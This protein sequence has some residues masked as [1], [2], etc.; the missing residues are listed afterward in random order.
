M[1]FSPFQLAIF[2]HAEDQNAGN[3][4]VEAVAG[5]GKTTTL[6]ETIKRLKGSSIFLAFNKSIADELKKRGVNARTF[7][8]L[9]Y[10]VVLRH[11]KVNE[12]TT[13]KLQRIVDAK[14]T[15]EDAQMY[16]A[17]VK[18]LVGLARQ[19]G[20]GCLVNDNDN[21]WMALVEH[22]DLQLE[23]ENAVMER[24]IE[25]ARKTLAVSNR[26]GM[27]DFD[28]MLYLAVRDGLVLPKF[29]NVLVDEAQDTNA[30]QRAILRKIMHPKSRLIAVGDPAQA[31]YGFRGADSNSMNVIAEEFNCKR[32][33][34]SISYRCAR[35]VV[36]YA[37]QWVS[38][39]QAAD[40]AIEGA[41]TNLGRD[42][43][44]NVFTQGDLIVCRKSAPVVALGFKLLRNGVSA[45]IM[46][47]ELGAGLVKLVER[48]NAGSI[49][50][51][52]DK[53]DAYTT[54]E[55]EKAMAKKEEDKA[56]QIADKTAAVLTICEG[57]AESDRTVQGVVNAINRLFS[58]ERAAVTLATIHKAKGLESDRVF[59]LGRSECPAQWARQ[60]WQKV[61]EDNLCYVAATR[62]K[63]ELV[64]IEER[65]EG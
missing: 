58:D 36:E 65:E 19:V 18:R 11:K 16:G 49:E 30:I 2:N 45:R 22:H 35:S 20:I 53:L 41:V 3:A 6:V 27:I 37:Q 40:T 54:R 52:T 21:E 9:C 34:L 33:P 51:L 29:D 13:N 14:F 43:D 4:I 15:G 26:M 10:G 32:L 17:F 56:E 64:L 62:A 28:D 24:A 50:E 25:L 63:K 61:Q 31:I 39:I 60:E 59:W 55:V 8:S 57:L 46:G 38:H 12:V 44:H 1:N 47:R 42:W 7:H 48:M 5:S 23:N